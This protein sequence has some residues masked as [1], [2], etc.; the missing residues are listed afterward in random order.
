MIAISATVKHPRTSVPSSGPGPGGPHPYGELGL[1]EG[2]DVCIIRHHCPGI[3][4]RIK[5]AQATKTSRRR[6]NKN[7]LIRTAHVKTE[8]LWVK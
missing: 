7:I 2:D 6:L 1:G 3:K 5:S 4:Y 8:C